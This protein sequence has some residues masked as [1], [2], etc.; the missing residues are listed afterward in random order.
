MDF[1]TVVASLNRVLGKNQPAEFN[2][3][4][5]R[6]TAPRC[7]RFIQKNVRREYGGIDW[8]RLTY[9]LDRRFQRL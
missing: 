5:I 9:A 4:W 6:R 8:D 7:Y 3:S 2:S 1:E